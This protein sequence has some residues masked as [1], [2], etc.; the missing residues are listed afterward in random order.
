MI[1]KHN[2]DDDK[3]LSSSVIAFGNFDGMHLGHRKIIKKVED[4]A[5]QNNLKSVV[6]TFSPHTKIILNKDIHFRTLSNFSIK[7]KLL[8]D[9]NIDIIC[10]ISFSQKYANLSYEH[11]IDLLIKKYNPK[12]IVFGYDNKFGKNRL[13]H[14]SSIIENIKYN[15]INF[16]K[17]KPYKLLGKDV[18][19][20]IIKE[21]IN[22]GNIINANK[23]LGYR[24]SI[25]GTVID[26]EKKGRSIGF[27]TA[28][29]DLSKIKQLIPKNGVYSVTLKVD[30][31][32]YKA[33]C[34]IGTRPT[35]SNDSNKSFEIHVLDYDINLY[36]KNINVE[37]NGFIR[38]EKKF[39]NV[40]ELSRQIHKDI[41]T[42]RK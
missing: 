16:I 37:F 2:L 41:L 13:G 21:F 39:N 1:I 9:L 25:S 34:N 22:E 8:D 11:F 29:L 15:N 27:P 6:L 26:G 30:L 33:I 36:G 42:I 7:S 17:I 32:N 23:F 31:N 10:K 4:I 12:Y 19:T 14:Y 28:N 3:S 40:R 24:Y 18:K 35:V 20:T 5:H 38:K